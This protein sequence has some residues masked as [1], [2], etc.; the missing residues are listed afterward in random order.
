MKTLLLIRSLLQTMCK[1][2]EALP[3]YYFYRLSGN[4][5]TACL[6]F[7]LSEFKNGSIQIYYC[8]TLSCPA[9]SAC[10]VDRRLKRASKR[11]SA[12]QRLAER[13]FPGSHCSVGGSAAIC[14]FR[15]VF[16]QS[17]SL[18]PSTPTAVFDVYGDFITCSSGLP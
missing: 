17:A 10:V 16:V 15:S 3:F 6:F 13:G 8:H 5:E 7:L 12:T 18:S 1:M 14:S 9:V 11:F 2:F 4:S